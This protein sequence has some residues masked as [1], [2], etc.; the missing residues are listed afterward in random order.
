[1]AAW[2]RSLAKGKWPG[3]G[4][5]VGMGDWV[6][7]GDGVGCGDGSDD[8]E[9]DAPFDW[10]VGKWPWSLILISVSRHPPCLSCH[11]G[12]DGGGTGFFL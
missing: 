12:M 1:M 3:E 11:R 2:A 7:V 8:P 5:G 9:P 10:A 4:T 6:G